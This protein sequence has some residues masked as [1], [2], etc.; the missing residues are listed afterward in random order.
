[1]ASLLDVLRLALPCSSRVVRRPLDRLAYSALPQ[2]VFKNL[3]YSHKVDV[4]SFAILAYEV[5]ARRR[6]YSQLYMTM[7]QV[8]L[9]V[10]DTD[11]RPP[12]PRSWPQPLKD[13]IAKCWHKSAEQRPEFAEIVLELEAL[14][15]QAEATEPGQPN[16]LLDALTPS[17][18]LAACCTLM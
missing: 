6:A 17:S 1:M 16:E 10:A 14:L 12:L 18:S 2:E 5:L 4:F 11:L 7:E 8:A 3:P 13:L 9:S 15:E